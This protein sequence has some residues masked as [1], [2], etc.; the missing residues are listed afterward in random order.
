[1]NNSKFKYK[2]PADEEFFKELNASL[3]SMCL[4]SSKNIN[5]EQI[6]IIFIVGIPRSGTTLLSQLIARY[7]PVGYINNITAR[8]WMR[9]S[10]GIRLTKALYLDDFGRSNITF[11][12]DLGKTT[13]PE[14]PHEFGYF[15]SHWLNLKDYPTHNLPTDALVDKKGLKEVLEN[16]IISNIGMPAVVFKNLI[17]GFQAELLTELHPNSIFVHVKR[18]LYDSVASLLEAR[19]KLFGNYTTFFSLKPST[20]PFIQNL[21][22]EEEVTKQLLDCE[23]E[24]VLELSKQSVNE[25]SLYYEDVCKDPLLILK[26]ICLRLKQLKCNIDPLCNDIPSFIPSKRKTG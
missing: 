17:C 15:W 25:I 26:T 2:S 11:K 5:S 21:S 19:K 10:V 7:L 4:P 3:S 20:Y 16:E 12:S 23:N 13:N 6:P 14:D 22:P 8:F 18:N 9:P 1:V 24:I